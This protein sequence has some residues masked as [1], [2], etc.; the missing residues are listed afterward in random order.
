MCVY[1]CVPCGH[2]GQKGAVGALVLELWIVVSHHE[3]A[4]NQ[5]WFL[6]KS[7]QCAELL[8]Q[9]SLHIPRAGILAESRESTP[10]DSTDKRIWKP[11]PVFGVCSLPPVKEGEEGL[12]KWMLLIPVP[13][14]WH[15]PNALGP[16][17]LHPAG[18]RGFFLPPL[19]PQPPY[20]PASS[21]PLTPTIMN[22]SKEIR[23][24]AE[25]SG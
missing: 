8:S 11:L 10:M 21:C 23:S 4:G 12:E 13:R 3:G 9:H 20:L 17:Q 2:R 6:F 24:T 19:S 5:T 16:C 22:P 7:P 15:T 18:S 25:G 14:A 1:I